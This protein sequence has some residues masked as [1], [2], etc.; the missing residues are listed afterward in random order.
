MKILHLIDSL[1]FGGAQIVV[2]N[3]FEKSA[4]ND[5]F[6]LALRKTDRTITI[7]HPNIIS[8]DSQ[9]RYSPFPLFQIQQIIKRE[10]I[11]ILHCHLFRSQVFGWFVKI[12][13]CPKVKLV[14]HE[15]GQIFGTDTGNLLEDKLFLLFLK[16]AKNKVDS[17]IAVS[18]MTRSKLMA[19]ANIDYQKITI[20]YNPVDLKQFNKQFSVGKK[21]ANMFIV[22][23]AGRLVERKG[24]EVYLEAIEK[25]LKKYDNIMFLIA[26]DGPKKSKVINFISQLNHSDKVRYLG[27]IQDMPEFYSKLD[28]L[29]I[30]S[31]WEAMPMV[32]IETQMAGVPIIVS[33]IDAFKELITNNHNGIFFESENVRDLVNKIELLLKDKDL[34]EKIIYNAY[35]TLHNFDILNYLPK[36]EQLYSSIKGS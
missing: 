5:I 11:D 20:L 16:L 1:D 23:F 12:F 33:Y 34:R 7:L 25:I 4:S 36:L 3:I 15:H 22:G 29:V 27:Y 21:N 9:S 30:P 19:R 26:G 28:C 6:L 14:F 10:N 17:F 35:K 8:H 18:K 2:K 32:V 13:F 31:W 24:I